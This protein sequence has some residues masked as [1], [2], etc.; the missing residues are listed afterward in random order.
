M[1]ISTHPPSFFTFSLFNYSSTNRIA[2]QRSEFRYTTCIDRMN[3]MCQQHDTHLRNRVDHY[4]S[5]DAD[6]LKIVK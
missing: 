4:G 1:R 6:A 3:A 5:T 2:D